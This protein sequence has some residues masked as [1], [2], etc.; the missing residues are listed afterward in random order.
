MVNVTLNTLPQAGPSA[1]GRTA[2]RMRILTFTTL[3]PN[4]AQPRHGI[5]VE[6]RLRHLVASGQVEARVVAACPWFPFGDTRFGGYAAYARVPAREERFGITVHHPRFVIIPKISM[7]VAP[8]LLYAAARKLLGRLI[9]EGFDFDLIDSHYA[10]PD[11]VAAVMLGRHFGRPVTITA[12]GSDL[13]LISD[14][15]LPRRMI[16]WAA[17][18]ADGVITVAQALKNR[19]VALGIDGER[20]RVLRNGVDLGLFRPG[21]RAAARAALGFDGP[22]LL[23][24]GNLIPLKGH[25]LVIEALAALPNVALTVVGDGPERQRLMAL[26]ARLGVSDRVRFLGIVAQDRLPAVYTAADILVL[27]SSSEGWANVL[28]EAM[29]C[30]TPV[31][32]TAV[33]GTPEVVAAPA[34]GR[35]LPERSAA[36]IVAAV[37]DLLAAPPDRAATRAYAEQFSWDSTTAG[38]LDLFAQILAR[39]R[40]G[41]VSS[42]RVAA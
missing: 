39:R 23:S 36:A 6:S 13:N 29:A 4:A 9:A 16:R 24:V 1:P 2:A 26:A 8:A 42:Q 17:A 25:H 41:A 38:Q 12:R 33:S 14:Y 21:D 3:Y 37:H 5:F 34:A 7:A 28:L 19:A 27:A 32:A 30:G 35:L 18:H 31:V 20:I 11:G 22:T 40:A 15:A 10:Y